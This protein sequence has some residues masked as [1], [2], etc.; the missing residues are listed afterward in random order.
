MAIDERDEDGLVELGHL[1]P[2][3]EYLA[4]LWDRRQFAVV[5]PFNDLRVQNMNTTLGQLW[6]VINPMMQIAV[7]FIVFGVL[8]DLGG[9]GG[10]DNYL[11]FLIVGILMFTLTTRVIT[12]S[13][14]A[15]DRDEGLIRSVQFPRALLPISSVI[16]QTMGFLP[17]AG[18]L[19]IA[20][21]FTG[22][23]PDATWLAFP[24][25]LA[26]QF[27]INLGLGLLGARAGFAVR[28]LTQVMTHVMRM[29]FY[30]SGVIFEVSR[31][32]TE[33]RFPGYSETILKLFALNPI[34][35]I[36]IVARWSLVD[37]PLLPEA[38]IGFLAYAIILPIVGMRYF[39]KAEFRYGG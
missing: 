19:V 31:F 33:Q 35:D 12:D 6:H 38:A 9:R 14:G 4:D 22:E 2:M 21:V 17:A 16:E 10:I 15:M 7:Y 1:P 11:A 29:L 13:V 28:D 5:V 34:Y 30:L 23:I 26:I 27:S 20:V 39:V 37:G 24:F 3:N 32:V 18:V 8:L 25:I 36:L